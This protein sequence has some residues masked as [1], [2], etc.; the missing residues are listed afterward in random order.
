MEISDAQAELLARVN[1]VVSYA[2]KTYANIQKIK[3]CKEYGEWH[4]LCIG[5]MNGKCHD[6]ISAIKDFRNECQNKFI[7][8][9]FSEVEKG[10]K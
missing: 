9:M 5:S 10:D 8:Q 2:H 3:Y 6:L 1:E 7:R 4:N